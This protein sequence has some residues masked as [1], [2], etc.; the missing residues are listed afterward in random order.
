[1]RKLTAVIL[2]L[3][4]C[5]S[6]DAKQSKHKKAKK[7]SNEIISVE[8]YHTACFGRCPI[9]KVDVNKDGIAT[10]TGMR[11]TEDSGVYQKKIGA[12]KAQAL[13]NEFAKYRIDTCKDHY[14]SLIQDVPGIVL[15]IRY[16]GRNKVINDAH[17]APQGVL[18]LSTLLTQIWD[19]PTNPSGWNKVSK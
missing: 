14:E 18:R 11:F 15:T 3:M 2:L 4:C 19:K 7:V 6:A 8:V 13:L 1:M 17:F 9:Y 16:K 10:Y 5:I 12:R